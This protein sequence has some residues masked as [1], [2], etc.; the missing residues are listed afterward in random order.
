MTFDH[1]IPFLKSASKLSF[2]ILIN[3][4]IGLIRD[5]LQTRYFG[6]NLMSDAYV[7]AWKIP[8]MFRRVF[9]EGLLSSILLPE[10][11]KIKQ[12][13][14]E[15]TLFSVLSIITIIIQSIILII[16]L[17]ISFKAKT[18]MHFLSAGNPE[19][20]LYGSHM[21]CVL[22]FFT[23]FMTWSA[24]QSVAVQLKNNF[25]IGPQSQ[26][27]LNIVLCIEFI[28][29][30]KYKL[31]YLLVA[32][33]ISANGILIFIIH[34]IAFSYYNFHYALPSKKS[35]QLSCSFFKK[36]FLGLSTSLFLE[37]NSFIG[38]SISSYLK[39]GLITLFETLLT[40]IRL[41]Q[42]IFGNALATTIN[43]E[44]ITLIQKKSNQLEL[45]ISSIMKYYFYLSLIFS[46]GVLICGKLFFT[47]FFKL[48]N[49]NNTFIPLAQNTFFIMSLSLFPSL[50]TK[51]LITLLYAYENILTPTI[52]SFLVSMLQNVG[53]SYFL[54]LYELEAL[55]INY[56]LSDWIRFIILFYIVK[57][58]Y[59]INSFKYIFRNKEK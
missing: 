11:V 36:F 40:L 52:I 14:S 43:I 53:L 24:I 39:P 33:M 12:Q 6:L 29:A 55:A 56:F 58:K 48:T 2:F 4:P 37:S 31:S 59:E 9:G 42:Q 57:K 28:I 35:L 8:N 46:L 54:S 30:I 10:L 3:K 1:I 41:P 7:A 15:S 13:E 21:L 26:F 38:F 19:R 47:L 51:I 27:V 45:T 34:S 25:Y 18:I 22:I 5:I 16:C 50:G 32:T 23:F 44:L 17:I 20:I 49:I